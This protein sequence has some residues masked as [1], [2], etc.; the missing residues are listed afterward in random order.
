MMDLKME[1]RVSSPFEDAIEEFLELGVLKL[2]LG[3]KVE[4]MFCSVRNRV[5]CFNL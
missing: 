5:M 3:G 2:I 1:F 4:M